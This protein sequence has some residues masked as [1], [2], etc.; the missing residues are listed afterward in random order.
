MVETKTAISECN[1]NWTDN[2]KGSEQ[3]NALCYNETIN[4]LLNGI[5]EVTYLLKNKH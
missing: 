3:T 4:K 2:Q 5:N 1:K